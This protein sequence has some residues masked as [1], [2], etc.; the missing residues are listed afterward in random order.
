[1]NA[2]ATVVPDVLSFMYR[3]KGQR[4][5]DISVYFPQLSE[6][7]IQ[8]ALENCV[9]DGCVEKCDATGSSLYFKKS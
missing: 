4:V 2:T 8:K 9:V 5:C 7:E 6:E 3:G 1:M